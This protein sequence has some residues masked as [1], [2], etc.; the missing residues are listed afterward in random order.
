MNGNCDRCR[1]SATLEAGIHLR[2]M[3]LA[4]DVYQLCGRCGDLLSEFM[5][6]TKHPDL[7]EP[8]TRDFY[9]VTVVDG[10]W[11][12]AMFA[13][14]DNAVHMHNDKVKDIMKNSAAAYA[15]SKVHTYRVTLNYEE[16]MELR[17]AIAA[18]LIPKARNV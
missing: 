18:E 2:Q 5:G 16:E 11:P 13:S 15:N 14:V 6:W 4:G 10:E 7:P 9:F 12:T 3:S 1:A 17:P 8:L